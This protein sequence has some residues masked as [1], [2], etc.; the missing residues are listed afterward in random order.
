MEVYLLWWERYDMLVG[1][2][3]GGGSNGGGAK[4]SGADT[5]SGMI[6]VVVRVS[7][8]V[9]EKEYEA[10]VMTMESGDVVE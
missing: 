3:L 6:L 2:E 9:V 7:G 4:G 10:V 5:G 1:S 8:V